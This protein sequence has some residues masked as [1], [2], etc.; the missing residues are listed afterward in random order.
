MISENIRNILDRIQKRCSEAGRDPK[1]VCLV[2]VSKNFGTEEINDAYSYGLVNFGENKALELK[3]KFETLGSKITWHFIG[4]LQTN[5]VKYAAKA[6]S[7][8]HSV[9]SLKLAQEIDRQAE[10]Y[11][12]TIKVL[13]EIKTSTEE[14]KYGL[15][16]IDGILPV[17]DYCKGAKNI[18]L[19]GLMTMAPNTDDETEIRKSFITL[20]NLK[21]ELNSRGHSLTELSMGMTQ[22]FE[23]A[24]DEGATMVRIGTAI[25]GQK[26]LFN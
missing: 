10:K 11:S 20:R 25:F 17:A 5:K 12:K 6:A 8:I 22:D 3:D 2:A 21:D 9:D 1:E 15:K 7:F 18:E 19:V 4:H 26:K 23:L 14:S 24:I 13:L 16:N